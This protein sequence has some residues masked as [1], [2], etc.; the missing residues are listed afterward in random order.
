MTEPSKYKDLD[1]FVTKTIPGAT[2]N[3]TSGLEVNFT[4]PKNSSREFSK[5]FNSFETDGTNYG[6]K[7]FGVS[8]TT[9]EE[10]FFK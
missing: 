1:K 9:I 7:S 4:L 10:V 6:V 8:V 3:N 5:L 2:L